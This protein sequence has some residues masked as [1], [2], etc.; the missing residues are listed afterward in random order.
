MILYDYRFS[1]FMKNDFNSIRKLEEDYSE[2]QFHQAYYNKFNDYF[3]SNLILMPRAS[4]QEL[5]ILLFRTK[6][7]TFYS[8]SMENQKK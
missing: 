1:H 6:E 5:G 8:W 4:F 2:L 3:S 7:K